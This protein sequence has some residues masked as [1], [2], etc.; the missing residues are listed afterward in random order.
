MKLFCPLLLLFTLLCGVT[1]ER[2][3]AQMAP[4]LT[5]AWDNDRSGWNRNET[6]LTQA[7]VKAKSGGASTATAG[8]RPGRSGA[9]PGKVPRSS[10][11]T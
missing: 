6:V 7:A 8:G 11:D 1:T 5:R 10:R 4:L 2:S 3:V 9:A